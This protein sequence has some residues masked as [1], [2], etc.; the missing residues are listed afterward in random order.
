VLVKKQTR[1]EWRLTVDEF[2]HLQYEPE[3]MIRRHLLLS[4]RSN[5]VFQDG[6]LLLLRLNDRATRM[7]RLEGVL[8]VASS[9]Q[10]LTGHC[11]QKTGM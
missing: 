5:V 9:D 2:A 6:R 8:S 4:A 11:E 10:G 3:P 1:R 7:L